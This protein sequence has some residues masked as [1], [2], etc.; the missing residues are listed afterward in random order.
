MLPEII[1][2]RR[3]KHSFGDYDCNIY[4]S[5]ADDS[6]QRNRVFKQNNFLIINTCNKIILMLLDII[7]KKVEINVGYNNHYLKF[8][9]YFT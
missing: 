5:L 4:N 3:L 6:K 1:K 8:K 7:K 9:F 2:K